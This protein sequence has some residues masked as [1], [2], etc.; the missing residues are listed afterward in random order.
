MIQAH[1]LSKVF[2]NTTAVDNISFIVNQG[3]IFGLLGP[4]GAGKT[5][6]MRMLTGVL[7]PTHG[8]I[9]IGQQA[10]AAK[11]LQV[12]QKLAV[13]PEMA[14]AYIDLSALDNLLLMGQLYGLNRNKRQQ[15]ANKL[16]ELFKLANRKKQLV[17][18]Y[19]KGMRQRVILAMA[20]M[21]E[22]E[23][24]VLDEPTSGLDVASVRLIRQLIR[25]FNQQGLTIFLTTHNIEEANM[26]CDRVA[27]MN[28]GQIVTIDRPENL[29]QTIQSTASIEVS[30]REPVT[31]RDLK[32]ELV[33]TVKKTGDK[34][35]LYTQEVSAVISQL[36]NYAQQTKNDIMYLNT[37]GPS[38]E[39]VFVKLTTQSEP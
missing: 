19:S 8:E 15:K 1:H 10:L 7:T 13:V 22:A 38:L 30:F 34:Y 29:K 21:N 5:T 32:F 36:V 33:N 27:I 28:H 17:K 4:N 16:L 3:E 24:L 35:R 20:L 12:K 25:K 39:D 2:A 26:L 18:T 23:I 6:T 14:N 37:L 9:I 11:P 31:A